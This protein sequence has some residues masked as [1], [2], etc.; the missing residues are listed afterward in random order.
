MNVLWNSH[1]FVPYF[2]VS[3]LASQNA[4]NSNVLSTKKIHSLWKLFKVSRWLN[5]DNSMWPHL[6]MSITV[7]WLATFDGICH[8]SFSFK[9]YQYWSSSTS[10]KVMMCIFLGITMLLQ[11]HL[12][13]IRCMNQPLKV[14]E[15]YK[16]VMS[17]YFYLFQWWWWWYIYIYI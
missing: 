2:W 10:I 9:K 14:S 3:S 4:N 1:K 17:I 16:W 12:G 11:C 15:I 5:V 7:M 13:K 6:C 8:A